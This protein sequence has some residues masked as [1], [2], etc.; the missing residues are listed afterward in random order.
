MTFDDEIEDPADGYQDAMIKAAESMA[1]AQN[2][3]SDAE[4][5][6]EHEAKLELLTSASYHQQRATALYAFAAL[7]KDARPPKL[8]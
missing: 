5:I 7:V 3:F 4:L 1:R 8:R 2:D 6:S